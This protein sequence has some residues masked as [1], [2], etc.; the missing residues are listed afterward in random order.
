LANQI[1]DVLLT[2]GKASV[3]YANG[4]ET[5]KIAVNPGVTANLV[6]G[7]SGFDALSRLGIAAGTLTAP[8][9]AGGDNPPTTSSGSTPAK[10]VYGLDFNPIGTQFDIVG[11][12]RRRERR[13]AER[14]E[15]HPEH[16]SADEHAPATASTTPDA[17]ANGTA[18]AYL[19]SQLSN[20]N[21]ALSLL[22]AVRPAAVRLRRHC[23]STGLEI[24]VVEADWKTRSGLRLSYTTPLYNNALAGRIAGRS[25]AVGP[26]RVALALHVGGDRRARCLRSH[27]SC[28]SEAR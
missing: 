13:S 9:K 14:R 28:G 11:E 3:T 8:A 7:P 2:K 21:V 19:T 16:L 12:R 27:F 5:L 4:G 25:P 15:H 22:N 1:N 23:R 6:P 10:P 17:D 26:C 24:L 18:P 20:Y